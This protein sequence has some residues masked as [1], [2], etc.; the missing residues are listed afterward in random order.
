MPESMPESGAGSRPGFHRWLW[1][2]EIVW[3]LGEGGAPLSKKTQ[4]NSLCLDRVPALTRVRAP[5]S[6]EGNLRLRSTKSREI[7]NGKNSNAYD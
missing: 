5:R 7:E 1:G 4:R 2:I 6:S 3:L